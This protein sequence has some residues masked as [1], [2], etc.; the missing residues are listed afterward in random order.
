RESENTR[1]AYL[2]ETRRSLREREAAAELKRSQGTQEQAKAAQ[3]E[4]LTTLTAPVRG[5]VQQLATHTEGGVVSD[6][7]INLD[8]ANAV[9]TLRFGAGINEDSV[10]ATRTNKDLLLKIDGSTDQ[11]QIGDYY[12]ASFTSD[13]VTYD[14]KIDRVEFSNGTVWDQA[15]IQTLVDRADGPNRAPV[16]ASAIADK[17]VAAGATFSYTVPVE[18]FADPDARQLP[19]QSGHGDRRQLAVE[20]T[21][22]AG[23]AGTIAPCV[24][25]RT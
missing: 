21:D 16:I 2:A 6:R 14:R 25:S 19:K 22:C 15:M 8:A 7:I 24:S 20:R 13:G 5:T 4:K 12:A 17:T 23:H 3:R 18:A 9:D 1:G 10:L 11:I